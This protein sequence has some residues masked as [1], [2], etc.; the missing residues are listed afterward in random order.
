MRITSKAGPC[1]RAERNYWNLV[2][3]TDPDNFAYLARVP[4]ETH[5]VRQ[6]RGMV[7]LATAVVFQLSL[8]GGRSGPEKKLKLCERAIQRPRI[9]GEVHIRRS[10]LTRPTSTHSTTKILPS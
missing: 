4:G 7:R 3:R 9:A 5:D 1:P 8:R 6:A 10:L 2:A